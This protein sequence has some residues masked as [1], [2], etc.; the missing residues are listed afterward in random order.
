MLYLVCFNRR[1]CIYN[2][3]FVLYRAG[4]SGAVTFRPGRLGIW[5]WARSRGKSQTCQELYHTTGESSEVYYRDYYP[6]PCM[7][8]QKSILL[9][10]VYLF[11]FS[12][13]IWGCL[14]GPVKTSTHIRCRPLSAVLAWED[15][16]HLWRNIFIRNC[17]LNTNFTVL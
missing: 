15:R 5:L 10:K 13:V 1:P 4:C 11:K 17:P 3:I 9:V 6:T 12:V 2:N 8:S 14:N 7:I 16:T